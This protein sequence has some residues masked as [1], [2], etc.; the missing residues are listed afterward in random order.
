MIRVELLLAAVNLIICYLLGLDL[1]ETVYFVQKTAVASGFPLRAVYGFA[2]GLLL[3][4]PCALMGMILPIG[5]EA[6]QRD[7]KLSENRYVSW[8]YAINTLGGVLGAL[9]GLGLLLP[10][11]RQRLTLSI[12]ACLNFGAAITFFIV[13][14][15]EG[16]AGD[17]T[18]LPQPQCQ[19]VLHRENERAFP[20]FA[21]LVF[22]FGLCA[23]WYEMFLYRAVAL[24]HEP[25]PLVFSVVLGGF[26]LFWSLG[27]GH[28]PVR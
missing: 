28:L 17:A 7:L 6:C 15:G 20:G 23:L 13:F 11:F 2:A 25:L 19:D 22:G 14:R 3:T 8:L 21:I 24:R 5:A 27:W 9:L 26:L 12:A 16:R 4:L 18:E 1:S 10:Q